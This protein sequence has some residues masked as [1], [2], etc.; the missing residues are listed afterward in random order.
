MATSPF[1]WLNNTGGK[2]SSAKAK[3][4]EAVAAA[5]AARALTP[6]TD[7]GSGLGVLGN[8]IGYKNL[9]GDI[10]ASED[11]GRAA[12]NEKFSALGAD[13]S[14]E[15]LI[16]MM[17]QDW[18]SNDQQAVVNA[19][20]SQELDPMNAIALEQAQ[21]NLEQ[22]R[23][24]AG[25]GDETFFGNIVP[26]ERPDGS[27]GFGQAGNRGGF[28]ELALPEGA[29]PAPT[30]KTIDTGAEIITQDIYGNELFRTPKQNQQ[31]AYDKAYGGE[32]GK[33]AAAKIEALPALL[34]KSDNMVATIEGVLNDPALDDS[35]GWLSFLQSVPGTDQYRFGQRALQL[36]GQS[37]LQAFESLKGGG[38]IT[39]VE[40]AKATQ[41]IGRLSTAQKPDDYR[42]ALNE[43]KAIIQA[44]KTRA[45]QSAG[46]PVPQQTAPVGTNKTSTGVG[47]G[48]VQ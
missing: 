1:T 45:M 26:F 15:A 25:A 43:L 32:A 2:S 42:A 27:I 20:L 22:D 30:T 6:A 46:M 31:E 33:A 14:R 24:G 9:S 23:T 12:Y 8:A 35:T 34:A 38:Q 29:K 11:A 44:S 39:E 4:D 28:N 7:L 40:G 17:G 37:F 3:R 48:I 19:L 10:T 13:P 47:W 36:Q 5:L 16:G 21:L 18:A 41:A